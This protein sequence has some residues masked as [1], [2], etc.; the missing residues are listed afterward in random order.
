MIPSR[1]FPDIRLRNPFI[2]W[3]P[4]GRVMAKADGS[5]STILAAAVIAARAVP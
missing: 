1:Q 5:P 3:L 2:A 4:G